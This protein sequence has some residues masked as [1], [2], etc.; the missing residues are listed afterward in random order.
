LTLGNILEYGLTVPGVTL[1]AIGLIMYGRSK[2]K[3]SE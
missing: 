1:L 3:I 2:R